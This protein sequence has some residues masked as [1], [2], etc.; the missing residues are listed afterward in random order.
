MY[1]V[2]LRLGLFVA[3]LPVVVVYLFIA[4]I[5][6]P[7]CPTCGSRVLRP[8]HTRVDGRA[9][10]RFKDNPIVCGPC[11]GFG[12]VDS[13]A[14]GLVAVTFLTVCV[15]G[16]IAHIY[17]SEQR[18]DE[19]YT[20]RGRYDASNAMLLSQIPRDV[21]DSERRSDAYLRGFRE[22]VIGRRVIILDSGAKGTITD[23]RP[24][25]AHDSD[26]DFL[27]TTISSDEFKINLDSGVTERVSRHGIRLL[28]DD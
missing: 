3:V 9:D 19:Q 22:K 6:K 2:F 20:R 28:A 26:G 8:L 17:F 7:R 15:Y 16:F 21:D 24:L 1:V 11:S 23:F 12:G 10:R 27:G 13:H 4:W 5:L 14:I 18:A 25:S